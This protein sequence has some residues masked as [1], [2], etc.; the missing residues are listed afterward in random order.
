MS[1]PEIRRLERALAAD[2]SDAV[3]LEAL[4]AART[5]AGRGWAGEPLPLD[6]RCSPRERGVYVWTRHGLGLEFVR[7]PGTRTV[8]ESAAFPGFGTVEHHPAFYVGRYPVTLGEWRALMRTGYGAGRQ[9]AWILPGGLHAEG[10][11]LP[12]VNVT[13]AD[14]L[15]FCEWA[16]LRLPTSAEWTR[17]ALG[18]GRAPCPAEGRGCVGGLR[19]GGLSPFCRDCS[20]EGSVPRLYPWGNEKPTPDRCVS[21]HWRF[22]RPGASGLGLPERTLPVR[23]PEGL[24][25]RPLGASPCGALDMVGHVW[26]RTESDSRRGLAGGSFRHGPSVALGHGWTSSPP[27]R[28]EDSI[29]FRVALSDPEAAP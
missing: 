6:L 15:A 13:H 17:A 9:T 4:A 28:A 21:G 22:V 8:R 11:D 12:I 25:A 29:G 19:I 5:R 3:A 10:H 26:E 27:T 23:T 18:D 24:P 2:T 16:G 7:V 14:A 20:G 1:D